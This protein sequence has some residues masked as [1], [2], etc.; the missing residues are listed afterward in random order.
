MLLVK[1]DIE[2]ARERLHEFKDR[3]E[4]GGN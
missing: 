2:K 3:L 4:N 1:I